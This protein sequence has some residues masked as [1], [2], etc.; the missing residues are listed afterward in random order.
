MNHWVLDATAG[1]GGTSTGVKAGDPGGVDTYSFL[2]MTVPA[3][4]STMSYYYSYPS[5]LDIGDD[6]HVIVDGFVL[7]EYETGPGATCA[8][9]SVPV[10]P[11]VTVS[12]YCRSGGLGETC[13]IDQVQFT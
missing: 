4:V 9:D 1:C 8:T 13:A 2:S 12:F 6:F 10:A 7:R 11:G 5:A 3:G